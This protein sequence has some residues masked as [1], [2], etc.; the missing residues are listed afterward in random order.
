MP[1]PEYTIEP[2][3]RRCVM[4]IVVCPSGTVSVRVPIM[5]D[6]AEVHRFVLQNAPWIETQQRIARSPPEL[7]QKYSV[8]IGDLTLPYTITW[9]PARKT[10]GILI[11]HDGRIEVRAPSGTTSGSV[12]AAVEKRK[13]WILKILEKR[14]NGGDTGL[15]KVY[16]DSLAWKGEILQ[17][18]V[19]TSPRAKRISIK[20]LNDRSIEV[21]SPPGANRADVRKVIEKK[22][23][24]IYNHVMSK[25]RA[26]AVR[27]T[28]CD[29]ETYPFL[30]ES[31]TVRIT[32]GKPG[33]SLAREGQ[34]I[35]IG[36]PDGLSPARERDITR[37]AVEY[38]LKNETFRAVM[39]RVIHY[40][41]VFGIG[42]PPVG[43]RKN[44]KRWGCCISRQRVAFT[45]E[46]C[47]LPPRLLDYVVAH[48]VCHMIVM[49]HSDRFR[50]TFRRVMPDFVEREAELKRDTPLYRFLPGDVVSL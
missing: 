1:I 37:R 3:A 36:L 33:I 11:H 39:P 16:R 38:T 46:V 19:R 6:P 47:M 22:V 14:Q 28:F 48:E 45:I 12:A 24:W 30:G 10:M 26:V 50:E 35:I 8:K 41:E 27:R 49:D 44:K 43:V 17:Y 4:T 5:H 20:I 7:P 9:Q 21:I 13:D 34:Y 42:V 2:S 29:G 32:R 18:S 23:E 31:L 15:V 25:A 40:S